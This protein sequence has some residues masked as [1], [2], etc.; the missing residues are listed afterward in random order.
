MLLLGRL[1]AAEDVALKIHAPQAAI[2]SG[3]TPS[4]DATIIN[5]GKKPVTL[6][7]PGDGSESGWRTPVVGWSVVSAAEP[8]QTHPA[9]PPLFPVY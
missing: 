4:F 1:A 9:E 2:H 7:L 5:Q 8:R 3:D 6:V